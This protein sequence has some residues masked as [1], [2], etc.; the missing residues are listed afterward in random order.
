MRTKE[1]TCELKLRRRRVLEDSFAAVMNMR[2]EDMKKRL[3]I[4]F[5][6]EDGLDYGG[7]SRYDQWFIPGSS[8][9]FPS[10]NGSS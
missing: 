9:M 5:E 4:R 3:A 10:G 1:G 8:L 2:G 7:V 6:G